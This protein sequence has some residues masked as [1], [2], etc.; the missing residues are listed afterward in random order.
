MTTHLIRRRELLFLADVAILAAALLLSFQL[1]FEFDVPHHEL[2][3]SI[4]QLPLVVLLQLGA[5]TLCGVFSFVSHYVGMA[6]VGAFVRAGALSLAALLAI[7]LG[8]P[9]ELAVLRVP[10]SVAFLTTILGIGGLLIARVGWRSWYERA[11]RER[12]RLGSATGSGGAPLRTL[13]VGAG[14]AG[15]LAARELARQPRSGLELVGFVDDDPA[16]LGASVHGIRVLGGTADLERLI[17]RHR[18][19]Q[20]VITMVR[21]DKAVLRKLVGRGEE[22]GV[23]VRLMPG[24]HDILEGRVEVSRLREVRIED[25]LGRDPIGMDKGE[26]LRLIGGRTVLLTGAGG[27]IGSELASQVVALRPERLLLVDRAEAALF[28]VHQELLR[29]APRVP[30][31]PLI[32]DVSDIARMSGILHVHR[33]HVLLH[34]AA[35]KHVPLMELNPCEAVRNNAL[36]TLSLGILAGEA[37]V[38]KFVLV[39]TDKAVRPSSIMGAS[40]RL[41]EVLVQDLDRRY[42][43]RYMAV[44]FGNVLGSTG[45]VIPIFRDQIAHGGPITVTHPDMVRYFM[46][47]PEAAQLVL[48]AAAMG[49]G[50]EIFVLDMGEP[51]RILDLAH[52]MIRLSGLEPGVDVEIEITG[53]R[54]GEKLHEELHYGDEDVARTAH[55]RVFIGRLQPSPA[56]CIATAVERLTGLIEAGDEEALRA[57]LGTLLPEACLEGSAAAGTSHA[58]PVAE[59]VA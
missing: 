2:Q 50:G 57:F 54:P 3:R 41:A 7:R 23:R 17:D 20:L 42:A 45:S 25:L 24:L 59:N 26:L 37:R 21:V 15:L 6:E 5:L 27:S 46:T 44:R 11:E 51:V 1:R 49:E 16:K 22:L 31:E 43:T 9:D 32:A 4:V 58:A 52:Q 53:I 48:Q 12:H 18:V 38:D 35:H 56:H 30:T 40:K 34:A 10:F 8:T 39:S 36:A 33:P 55:P 14:Q 28:A 47:I 29:L 19:E 13:L